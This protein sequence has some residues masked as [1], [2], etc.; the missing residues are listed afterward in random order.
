MIV[1]IVPSILV[2]M[3]VGICCRFAL[4]YLSEGIALF[5]MLSAAI[6]TMISAIIVIPL[7]KFVGGIKG[8]TAGVLVYASAFFVLLSYV[9]VVPTL[10]V[11][12]DGNLF[13]QDG[14]ITSYG[15]ARNFVLSLY[16]SLISLLSLLGLIKYESAAAR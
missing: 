5:S 6:W 13:F 3:T 7:Y 10:T 1:E 9:F 14:Y 8:M 2:F 4:Y 15:I 11:K 12:M 16:D